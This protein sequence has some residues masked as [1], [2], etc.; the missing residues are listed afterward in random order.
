MS[1]SGRLQVRNRCK[2]VLLLCCDL[3]KITTLFYVSMFVLLNTNR[4]VV[5]FG[6]GYGHFHCS[7]Q[8]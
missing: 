2:H 5:L 1:D 7:C 4:E 8:R 3:P 6:M